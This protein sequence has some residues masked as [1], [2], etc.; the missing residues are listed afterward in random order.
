MALQDY[1]KTRQYTKYKRHVDESKERITAQTVNKIQS[2]INE[3]QIETNKVKDTAFEERVYTIFNNNLYC[4]AMFI[5]YFRTGEYIN[6]DAS[7]S[8]I[9]VDYEKSWVTLRESASD[10]EMVSTRIE[11]VHGP[12][13]KVNDFFL[14]SNEIV[15]VGAKVEWYIETFTGELFPIS[16]NKLK[17]PMHIS[18]DL[19]NGF[20]VHCKLTANNMG[21]KPAVNGYAVL[22]WDAQVEADIGMTDPDVRRF[23]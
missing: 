21:E 10:G 16:Q 4:N 19:E 22:Y 17:T 8:G 6:M 13:I 1:D 20:K 7:T 2:D 9:Q 12:E 23:P 5:D 14:I 18:D 3:Q 15:P 11:S